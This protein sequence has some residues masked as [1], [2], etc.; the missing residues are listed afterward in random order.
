MLIMEVKIMSRCIFSD[1]E[2]KK[3]A[4]RIRLDVL[5][6]TANAGANGGHIGGAFSSAE[7]LAVL[8]GRV[9]NV[10]PE[11]CSDEE[12]DR[13]I[14][15]KGHCAIAHYVALKEAGFITEEDISAFEV[16]G[17]KFPTHEVM[18]LQSGIETSSGSLGYG[19]S[20]GIGV[21]LAAKLRGRKYHTY[22]LLGD[23]ECNEGTIWEAAM[24]AVRFG[25][26][27]LTAIVDVNGQSNDGMTADVMPVKHMA[28][29]WA[30]FGWHVSELDG[31]DVEQL[32]QA[33]GD[34]AEGSPHVLIAHTVKSKGIPSIEGK[35]GWHHARLT[36]VQYQNLLEELENAI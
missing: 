33:F 27:N 19:L 29:V 10:S 35:T 15:S 7:I 5:K 4:H 26:D 28:D 34:R 16:S 36:E 17:S 18:S 32:I 20:V 24:S 11:K 25:T 6:M 21:A 8:Y 13:F 23:G 12:R 22:V 1:D 9:M 2:L 14:L 31:N 30:G 3:F